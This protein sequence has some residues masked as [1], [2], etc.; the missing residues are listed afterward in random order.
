MNVT[1]VEVDF[2]KKVEHKTVAVRQRQLEVLSR[3]EMGSKK[4]S[5]DDA[6][7]GARQVV[8]LSLWS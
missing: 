8:L 3:C 6:L 2:V 5:R 4:N 1:E 7:C